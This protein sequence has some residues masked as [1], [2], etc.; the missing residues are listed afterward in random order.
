[1][2]PQILVSRRRHKSA[3]SQQTADRLRATALMLQT[4]AWVSDG[5]S[6]ILASVMP[7][8]SVVC[9][10]LSADGHSGLHRANAANA[11]EMEVRMKTTHRSY[12]EEASDFHRLCRF[13]REHHNHARAY[14]TWS[15]GRLVDW[16]Y[17]LYEN[18]LSAAAFCDKNAHLWFDSFGELAALA[19]SE[20]GDTGFAVITAEG[21]RFLFE[22][23]LRWVIANWSDRG[24]R[25]STEITELQGMEARILERFEFRHQSTFYTRRFD[26]TSKPL[27]RFPLEP[28]FVIVDML[29]Y[30]N[31][32]EQRILRAE[33][34]SGK[35]SLT[36]EEMQRQLEFYNYTHQG[37]IYHPQCDLC[38]MTEDVRCRARCASGAASHTRGWA[39]RSGLRSVD[40]RQEQCG[41]YRTDLYPQ[42]LPQTQLR[43][44][45]D[46]GMPGALACYGNAKRL[47]HRI[48]PRGHSPLRFTRCRGG[49]EIVHLRDSCELNILGCVSTKASYRTFYERLRRWLVSNLKWGISALPQEAEEQIADQRADERH[50][51]AVDHQAL[52]QPAAVFRCGRIGDAHRA[53][54]RE[55]ADIH[56]MTAYVDRR[57]N[58]DRVATAQRGDQA[59]HHRNKRRHHHP[60][61]A[62]VG[63][64]GSRHK[65]DDPRHVARS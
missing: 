12:A 24:S 34:F 3:R 5:R 6:K 36:E 31:Y 28:G 7:R 56:H 21:Y 55:W 27:K 52:E 63:R 61:R 23:I 44:S 60:R 20:N 10:S 2:Q 18:K 32:L 53:E 19:I 65:G 8:H 51:E 22:E 15:L 64:D 62:R 4:A 42:S 49:V 13:I 57:Y 54:R 33:A 16:K 29:T 45:S 59:R 9:T 17:G 26:L 39:V 25:F 48:Q 11:V 46:P 41:R 50:R 58:R 14:S 43:P 40:R 35:S 37:P 1:M 47:H 38:V 30:P